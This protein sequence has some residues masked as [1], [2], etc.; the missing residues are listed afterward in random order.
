M[1]STEHNQMV[2]KITR[3]LE[4]AEREMLTEKARNNE[5][6]IVCGDDNV[7]RRIPA[8]QVIADNLIFQD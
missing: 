1:S 6:V 8:K 7:I 3:G 5:N 2:E 4:I